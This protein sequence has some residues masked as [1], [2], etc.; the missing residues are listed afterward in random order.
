MHANEEEIIDSMFGDA[1]AEVTAHV[2]GCAKCQSEV[3]EFRRVFRLVY[4]DVP[5]MPEGYLDEAWSRLRPTL[6]PRPRPFW[7]RPRLLAVAA[8]IIVAVIAG[9]LTW[10]RERPPLKH[11]VGS[12]P[13]LV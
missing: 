3:E 10:S 5:E 8:A 4:D 9:L 11:P 12:L 1:G 6:T 13:K 7:R 2:A